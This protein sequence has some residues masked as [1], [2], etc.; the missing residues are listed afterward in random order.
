M[1]YRK[2]GCMSVKLVGAVLVIVACGGFGFR[3]AALHIRE[4]NNLREL[5]GVLDYME[6]ELQYRMTPLPELC[7]QGAA[8]CKGCLRLVFHRLTE[9][10]ED[11]ISPNVENCVNAVLNKEKNI[12]EITGQM[13]ELLGRSLGRFDI[14]GQLRGLESVRQEARRNLGL[15]CENKDLRLRTYQTLGLCTGAAL[16]ILFV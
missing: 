4:E 9:E 15:I 2:D 3:M 8:Q 5:I 6:C 14:D 16:A 1:V 7:R 11:Q 10:L 13:L 12:P